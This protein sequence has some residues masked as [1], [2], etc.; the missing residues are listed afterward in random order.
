MRNFHIN[1][2]SSGENLKKSMLDELTFGNEL[3]IGLNSLLLLK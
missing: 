3:G 1:A 2:I